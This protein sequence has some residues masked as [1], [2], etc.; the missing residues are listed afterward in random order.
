MF[1][2]CL[3]PLVLGL[4]VYFTKIRVYSLKSVLKPC[5]IA[6]FSDKTRIFMKNMKNTEIRHFPGIERTN[7]VSIVMT[8]WPGSRFGNDA[9]FL[10]RPDRKCTSGQRT[11]LSLPEKSSKGVPS[12]VSKNVS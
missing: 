8:D 3:F 4:T 10:T 6:A 2:P 5:S 9:T 1:I 7:S 11:G 12:V